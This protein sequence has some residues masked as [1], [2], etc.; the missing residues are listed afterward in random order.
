L[1]KLSRIYIFV[2]RILAALVELGNS[3]FYQKPRQASSFNGGPQSK[4]AKASG[5]QRGRALKSCYTEFCHFSTSAASIFFFYLPS[6]L[7]SIITS[8][9]ST[10]ANDCAVTCRMG[11][12]YTS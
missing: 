2:Q 9:S 12:L 3:T 11:V 6:F 1:Y 8:S 5:L 7:F 10:I 4:D